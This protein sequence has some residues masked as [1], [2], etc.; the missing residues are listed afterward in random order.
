MVERAPVAHER[1]PVVESH[2]NS[3]EVPHVDPSLGQDQGTIAPH[4]CDVKRLQPRLGIGEVALCHSQHPRRVL[5][6]SGEGDLRQ[7]LVVTEHDIHL[8]GERGRRVDHCSGRRARKRSEADAIDSGGVHAIRV[9]VVKHEPACSHG[10]C[11]LTRD[12]TWQP[13]VL[14]LRE[15][16]RIAVCEVLEHILDACDATLAIGERSGVI[17]DHLQRERINVDWEVSK[18]GFRGRGGQL[19]SS[20]VGVRVRGK[21]SQSVRT[22]DGRGRESASVCRTRA[23]CH[24]R[25]TLRGS[26]MCCA[27]PLR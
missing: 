13:L 27:A 12:R 9:T 1:L 20:I 15:L 11:L 25:E 21:S 3:R 2:G 10:I 26:D 24:R 6:L 4:N 8:A 23:G 17:I 5:E 19:P 7:A 18:E 22:R 16:K 14:K